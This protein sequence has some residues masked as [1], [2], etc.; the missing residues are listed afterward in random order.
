MRA[1][2]GGSVH[3]VRIAVPIAYPFPVV[4]NQALVPFLPALALAGLCWRSWRSI[5]GIGALPSDTPVRCTQY[6]VVGANLALNTDAA[7]S[8]AFITHLSVWSFI[9]SWL[10]F[11]SWVAAQTSPVSPTL[12]VVSGI[13]MARE[14]FLLCC[15]FAFVAPPLPIAAGIQSV[16]PAQLPTS[17]GG[18]FLSPDGHRGKASNHRTFISCSSSMARRWA[19]F[20]A[21]AGEFRHLGE[22]GDA[23]LFVQGD[24]Q[25]Q[26][27]Q[28][29][30]CPS[31]AYRSVI[32]RSHIRET[33]SPRT[34][35]R[36]TSPTFPG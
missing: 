31:V 11:L 26:A 15:L 14:S 32:R 19:S 28:A 29:Q 8:G 34:R 16:F 17:A 12:D 20:P 1:A 27:N 3:Y 4:V 2:I 13:L 25:F 6:S 5:R 10:F 9:S 21:L 22:A 18:Q 36:S 30:G 24:C 23:G 33:R 35:L 7:P